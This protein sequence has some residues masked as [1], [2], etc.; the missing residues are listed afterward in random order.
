MALLKLGKPEAGELWLWQG[1]RIM[2]PHRSG[3]SDAF[4]E[5]GVTMLSKN[6]GPCLWKRPVGHA[7]VCYET[8]YA[9]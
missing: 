2:L 3:W 9:W 4:I 6:F 8:G 5:M 7:Y 1:L